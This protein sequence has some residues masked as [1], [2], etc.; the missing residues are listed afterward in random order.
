MFY[1]CDL[2]VDLSY[3]STNNQVNLKMKLHQE[4]PMENMGVPLDL[5]CHS[6]D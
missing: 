3:G 5:R 1:F 2:E 4:G 6:R